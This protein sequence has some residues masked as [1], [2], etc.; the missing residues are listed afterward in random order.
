M[1]ATMWKIVVRQ[2]P[3]PLGAQEFPQQFIQPIADPCLVQKP[4]DPLK[5]MHKAEIELSTRILGGKRQIMLAGLRPQRSVESQSH[6][7]R[8]ADAGCRG[9]PCPHPVSWSVLIS[10]GTVPVAIGDREIWQRHPA[11]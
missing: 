1:L 4:A 11:V 2:R 8:L 7:M 6:V 5:I 10:E 3:T 9:Q